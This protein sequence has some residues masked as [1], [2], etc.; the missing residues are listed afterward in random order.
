MTATRSTRPSGS[1][2]NRTPWAVA[3]SAPATVAA[4]ARSVV[5]SLSVPDAPDA[6]G[7]GHEAS[8]RRRTPAPR[9]GC[10]A[11]I[12]ETTDE[13][14]RRGATISTRASTTA[15]PD[16][17]DPIVGDAV[18]GRGER[19]LARRRPRAPRVLADRPRARGGERVDQAFCVTDGDE[20]DVLV[21]RLCGRGVQRRRPDQTE[22]LGE[23]VVD[24]P[25][26][27]VRVGV[28][29]VQG[30]CRSGQPVQEGALERGRGDGVHRPQ[31]QRVVRHDE[32]GAPVA[33]LVDDGCHGVDREQHPADGLRR[34]AGD[35][36]D[37]V[38]RLGGRR[39]V[40]ALE[41]PDDV[42]PVPVRSR[43]AR[44][45][46]AS[47]RGRRRTHRRAPAP[48][49]SRTTPRRRGAGAGPA[50]RAGPCP[51]PACPGRSWSARTARSGPRTS[52]RRRRPERGPAVLGERLEVPST[53]RLGRNRRMSRA[54]AQAGPVRPVSRARAT[55]S[56]WSSA[57][58]ASRRCR[59]AVV[60][61]CTGPVSS[62]ASGS[63]N[64]PPCSSACPGVPGRRARRAARP[65][66][67]SETH[68]SAASPAT[69]CRADRVHGDVRRTGRLGD[70]ERGRPA[71]SGPPRR[72]ASP[73][74]RASAG[75]ARGQRRA[76][77]V[78]DHPPPVARGPAIS[79][80]STSSRPAND[81]TGNTVS[82]ETTRWLHME[83]P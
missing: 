23:R 29:R 65:A 12:A 11:R 19:P 79:A 24:A 63:A 71:R 35:Q 78:D 37:R 4:K 15:M 43:P 47:R 46:S 80:P 59:D 42:A 3:G 6:G 5:G 27:R 21:E 82:A 17:A 68:A 26:R 9:T 41:Q 74:R 70:V 22:R 10:A 75:L 31:E 39:R 50:R 51:S 73:G 18:V 81:F 55:R 83:G 57:A 58:H 32:V 48:S 76:V 28:R 69:R 77:R 45:R 25:G 56:S 67:S 52:A 44:Y 38:P 64:V 61:T 33:G 14:S 66:E 54:G 34:V 1:P 13:R 36:P 49:G 7:P 16:P 2:A 62:R 8:S 60:V 30:D 53:T 20:H 40:A 72:A